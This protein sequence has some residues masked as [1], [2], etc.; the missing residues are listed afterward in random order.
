MR[1]SCQAQ[2]MN[3]P[4]CIGSSSESDTLQASPGKLG[5][6]GTLAEVHTGSGEEPEAENDKLEREAPH[7]ISRAHA[8]TDKVGQLRL[9]VDRLESVM[10][11]D[12]LDVWLADG[13]TQGIHSAVAK[14]ATVI[15]EIAADDH[16]NIENTPEASHSFAQ[17][18]EK[19]AARLSNMQH[20]KGKVWLQ[21]N[22]W[23]LMM[24]PSSAG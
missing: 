9:R 21:N 22:K 3:H 5:G 18:L 12:A 4:P 2:L 6:N 23:L 20:H 17:T 19:S 8:L 1:L 16:F 13:E 14:A 7:D 15:T 24:K 11:R 10:Q